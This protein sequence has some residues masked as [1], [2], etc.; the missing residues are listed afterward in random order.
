MNISARAARRIRKGILDAR[1]DLS[2]VRT[3]EPPADR[4]PSRDQLVHHAWARTYINLAGNRKE[5]PPL[6]RSRKTGTDGAHGY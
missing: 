6:H 1:E 2:L 3:G 4:E 5:Q